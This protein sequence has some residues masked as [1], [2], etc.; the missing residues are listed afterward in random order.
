MKKLLLFICISFISLV[1]FSQNN[2]VLTNTSILEMVELGFESDLIISKIETTPSNFD[3][4]MDALK[5]LKSKNVASSII[6]A[7]VYASKKEVV[8]DEKTGI[9]IKNSD[10]EEQP[11]LPSAFSGTKTRTL[12]SAFTYGIASAKV[13]SVLNNASSKNIA[14]ASDKIVFMFYFKPFNDTQRLATDWWFRTTTSPN[15]F[16]LVELDVN[17][18]KETRELE[19]GKANLWVGTDAGANNKSVINFDIQDL[20]NG[21]YAVTPK[22]PLKS[23][24]YCFFYQ[25]TIPQGGYTNQS[26]FDFSVQ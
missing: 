16:V 25:G 7:M 5:M 1:S 19:T 26:V 9:Y 17:K 13:K 23:G 18:S 11:I 12:A 15:E 4:S 3:T 24:E 6:S 22:V 21:V 14:N 10:G 20:G 8:K 2:E